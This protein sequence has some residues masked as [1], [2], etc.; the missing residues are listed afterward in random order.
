MPV[1]KWRSCLW[2]AAPFFMLHVSFYPACQHFPHVIGSMTCGNRVR[3]RHV[4]LCLSPNYLCDLGQV[5]F[6]NFSFLF[7]KMG[8]IR[9]SSSWDVVWIKWD[10]KFKIEYVSHGECSIHF[11]DD[12]EKGWGK[13]DGKWIFLTLVPCLGF[14]ETTVVLNQGLFCFQGTLGNAQ[15]LY[16]LH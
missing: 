3:R 6:I 1:L 2:S 11:R 9:I 10:N 12:N 5:T 7:H 4:N 15:R 8:T 13:Q 14:N 16:W